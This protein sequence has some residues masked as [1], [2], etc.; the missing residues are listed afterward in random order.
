MEDV[1]AFFT[2]ELGYVVLL[3]V[4]FV[5]PRFLQRMRL[6]SALT[7]FALGIVASAGL[8]LFAGIRRS[9]SWR[10]SGSSRSFSSPA[11]R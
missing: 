10:P 7:S 5:V 6:P 9:T 2:T 4:L 8:G 3:F 11:S 1:R